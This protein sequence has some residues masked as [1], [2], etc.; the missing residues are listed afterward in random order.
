MIPNN[1]NQ[2]FE[3]APASLSE[4]LKS[5]WATCD[6]T[7]L[8]SISETDWTKF[9]LELENII[10]K[11]LSHSYPIKFIVVKD[12]LNHKLNV[13]PGIDL[14]MFGEFLIKEKVINSFTTKFVHGNDLFEYRGPRSATKHEESE[15]KSGKGQG[16]Y[17][18]YTLDDSSH[19]TCIMPIEEVEKAKLI[20]T[21]VVCGGLTPFSHNEFA[22]F[23]VTFRSLKLL[24]INGALNTTP[25]LA[26]L[27]SN[28]Y[29]YYQ[30]IFESHKL[31]QQDNLAPSVRNSRVISSQ[32]SALQ[33][34]IETMIT[35]GEL[36]NIISIAERGKA[37]DG[38]ISLQ[39]G[40]GI[41]SQF[42]VW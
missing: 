27:I 33:S 17:A 22:K 8:E 10:P 15:D 3:T 35:K 39:K 30:G 40:N 24:C 42:G 2:I 29:S 36:S 16:A 1:I 19:I 21:D 28:L 9:V 13:I 23:L 20:W 32:Q 12:N 11:K 6:T 18:T 4:S 14:A 5:A 41:I 31:N 37:D 38:I 26:Q 34:K 7:R 25:L